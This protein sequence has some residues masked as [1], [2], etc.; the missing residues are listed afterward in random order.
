MHKHTSTHIY[1]Y[2]YIHIHTPKMHM[3]TYAY[4]IYTHLYMHNFA[5]LL[6]SSKRQKGKK[7]P[8]ATNAPQPS[9]TISNLLGLTAW[10]LRQSK[11]GVKRSS[12]STHLPTTHS[13]NHQRH[14]R[15]T[16][17]HIHTHN[18]KHT[19]KKPH[20][21]QYQASTH[22]GF[23]A[24]HHSLQTRSALDAQPRVKPPKKGRD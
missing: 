2:I 23:L 10:F 13:S 17:K 5:Y 20:S 19:W 4:Y 16:Y 24:K 12:Q 22:A 11:L 7:H 21:Q 18:E 9:L 14:K 15:R 6:T 3:H 8:P 1:I